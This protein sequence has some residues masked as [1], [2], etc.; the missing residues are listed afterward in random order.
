MLFSNQ[1]NANQKEGPVTLQYN[2]S[3]MAK[4]NYKYENT[5]LPL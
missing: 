2:V 5:V 3:G 1:K 4:K